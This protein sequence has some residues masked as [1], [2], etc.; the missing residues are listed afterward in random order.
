MAGIAT[1]IYSKEKD[2][3]T[4]RKDD[5]YEFR[6]LLIQAYKAS[7]SQQ[8]NAIASS[9]LSSDK[10]HISDILKIRDRICW[11]TSGTKYIQGMM[12]GWNKQN[13]NQA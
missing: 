5:S 7:V 2:S 3:N 8:I 9:G 1:L 13:F 11:E 12:P 10:T 6:I 4:F